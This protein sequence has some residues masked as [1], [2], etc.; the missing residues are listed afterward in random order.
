ME[1]LEFFCFRADASAVSEGQ[2]LVPKWFQKIQNKIQFAGGGLGPFT[3]LGLALTLSS[4]LWSQ[5][6]LSILV[7]WVGYAVDEGFSTY[8]AQR[9]REREIPYRD[10]F[11]LWTPGILFVHAFLQELGLSD[12][13]SRGASAF[14]AALA[15]GLTFSLGSFWLRA[16]L[17]RLGLFCLLFLWGFSL[18][19]V[20][21]SSWYALTFSLLGY[22]CFT[23]GMNLRSGLLFALSFWFKQNMGILSFVA[24]LIG[25]AIAGK[26]LSIRMIV[27]FLVGLV[28]P[29]SVLFIWGGASAVAMAFQQIFLFPFEYRVKMAESLPSF[30]W[31]APLMTLGLW[32][33]SL[34]LFREINRWSIFGGLGVVIYCVFS[35]GRHGLS[36]LSGW[37]FLICL[38]SWILAAILLLE[39]SLDKHKKAEFGSLLIFYFFSLGLFAQ[40]YP[41]FDFQHFLFVFSLTAFWLVWSIERLLEKYLFLPKIW[42]YFPAILLLVGGGISQYRVLFVA[43]AGLKDPVGFTSFGQGHLLNEEMRMV[44]DFLLEQGLKPGDP[45]LVVPNATVFYRYSGFKN[46]TAHN[47]FFPSYVKAYGESEEDVLSRYESRGGRF[48]VFQERS[49]SEVFT[50]LLHLELERRY[51]RIKSFPTHFSVLQKRDQ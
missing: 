49:R 13:W 29:F 22:W 6:L 28:V 32:V 2:S 3:I 8:A 48:V 21:Y 7:D 50:P 19:N 10:F 36:F 5:S 15:S 4:F 38:V 23:K 31:G 51:K 24:L 41:R 43:G 44:K 45:V 46:V 30:V 18:W 39:K 34:Y 25:A 37:F 9:I 1:S 20:P 16:F 27:S 17:P 47:Q 11:F 14:F 42:V 33:M 12:L 26:R 40:V 35:F